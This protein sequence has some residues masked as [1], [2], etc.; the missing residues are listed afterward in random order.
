MARSIKRALVS[1]F[2]PQKMLE[3]TKS[4][5]NL[6]VEIWASSGTARFLSNNTLKVNEVESLTGFVRLIGGRVKTLHPKIFAGILCDR[7]NPSHLEDTKE[8]GGLLF[9]LIAVDLYPFEFGL[10][11]NLSFEGQR[12]LID[13][14]GV[15][16]IRAAAKNSPQTT[17]VIDEEGFSWV[18][19]ELNST[20]GCILEQT[21][22][23]LAA[24]AFSYTSYYDGLIAGFLLKKIGQEGELPERISIPQV[25]LQ[26]LRYGENP[27]QRA[28][29]YTANALQGVPYR[30]L[31]GKE[32]SYNNML[33]IEGAYLLA[34]EFQEPSAVLVKHTNPCGVAIGTSV[35]HAFKR[36][37][38]CD[39]QSAFG[40][41]FAFNRMVTRELA[42]KL[43][44]IF[45]EVILAPEYEPSALELIKRKKNLRVMI[46]NFDCELPE[47]EL[48]Q[49]IFGYLWQEKNMLSPKEA[50]LNVV[51]IRKP[52]EKE[53]NDLLFAF[54]VVKYVKS[55]AIVFARDGA[56][57]GIGAGQM[58][59]VDSVNLAAL[60]AKGRALG[61]CMASDAFFP[62]PDGIESAKK[63][64]IQ[65]VITPSGSIRDK[66]VI[67]EADRLGM[68]LVFA[69]ERHF[70]H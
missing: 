60:K 12:E 47:L 70:K 46:M 28:A 17:V 56:T 33:D 40:G 49:A 61:A 19:D 42:E 58:S 64:G 66:E 32:L 8:I 54:T 41:I 2:R 7:N 48:R 51:S 65:V 59:R 20:N 57:L 37:F 3:F 15:A 67:E 24:K 25:R 44:S 21:S 6:G 69:S 38:E 29:I 14:G 62:F 34:R 13:I 43:K 16:L 52:T 68:V 1:Y 11:E 27:H 9:D 50:L 31:H 10:K 4:L 39:S 35:S 30:M 22:Y 26:P 23:K 55:N 18:I 5:S 53:I 63:A 45:F 36:A